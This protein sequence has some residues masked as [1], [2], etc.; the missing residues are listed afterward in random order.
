MS[1][2]FGAVLRDV[3]FSERISLFPKF[4]YVHLQAPNE[5]MLISLAGSVTSVDKSYIVACSVGK[6]NRNTSRP[7]STSKDVENAL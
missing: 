3:S 5:W 7:P 2:I 4:L 6:T 1:S